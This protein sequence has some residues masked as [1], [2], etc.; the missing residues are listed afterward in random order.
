MNQWT[1]SD[2]DNLNNITGLNLTKAD[3][4][5]SQPK[6]I[7][8]TN[9]PEGQLGTGH[10]YT[11]PTEFG[12][13]GGET[14]VLDP[15]Y[16]STSPTGAVSTIM[17]GSGDQNRY[18][19]INGQQVYRLADPSRAIDKSKIK[20]DPYIGVYTTMDNVSHSSGSNFMDKLVPWVIGG[21]GALMTAG[22]L[23][24]GPLAGGAGGAG[25]STTAAAGGGS[26]V[27]SAATNGMLGVNA[28]N[29]GGAGASM[30]SPE[31]MGVMASSGSMTPELA[32]A[33][34]SGA[35]IS[36][37]TPGVMESIS[38]FVATKPLEAAKLGLTAASIAGGLGGGS[39]GSS[40]L[41]GGGFGNLLGGIGS[42]IVANNLSKDMLDNASKLADNIN[43]TPYTIKSSLGNTYQDPT[44]GAMVS[45]LS[46][47]WQQAN[48]ALLDNFY[49]NLQY[50]QMDPMQASQYAYNMGSQL[51]A[52]QDEQNRL[53]LENRLLAQGMLGSTGGAS[54][55]RALYDSMNQRDL[56]REAQSL[57]LGQNMLNNYQ[58]RAMNAY[59][60]LMDITK[61]L[62]NQINVSSTMG[63]Q[64]LAAEQTKANLLNNAYLTRNDTLAKASQGF[65]G[66]PLF[67]GNNGGMLGNL[68]N[69][70]VNA[71]GNIFGNNPSPTEYLNYNPASVYD[72]SWTANGPFDS[73]TYTGQIWD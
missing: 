1:Q 14:V 22:A 36:T 13:P 66:S 24:L 32:A 21:A 30:L 58:Q 28:V 40:G 68:I 4:F 73:S 50:S 26:F 59:N 41:F 56:G 69:T 38:N 35:A 34:G 12:Y 67:T 3:L 8:Y 64:N 11:E 7:T 33:I 18:P 39:G 52:Y 63:G 16:Y 47:Q 70:G 62:N 6:G 54:Q 44:T 31:L 55:M 19:V 46:P 10:W 65:F 61:T 5:G 9:N 2:L 29:V 23:G 42:G 57:Q 15:K 25:A 60:P 37:A 43:F 49:G 27:P 72:G 20:Y 17:P 71:V 48:N 53:G 45:E 51:N